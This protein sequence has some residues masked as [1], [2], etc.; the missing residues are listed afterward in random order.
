MM[1]IFIV[2]M[3]YFRFMKSSKLVARKV[4]E[5]VIG[6]ESILRTGSCSSHHL[7]GGFDLSPRTGDYGCQRAVGGYSLLTGE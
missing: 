2:K 5:P 7:L 6:Y 4:F 3:L 1:L